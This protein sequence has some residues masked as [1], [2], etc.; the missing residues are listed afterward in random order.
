MKAPQSAVVSKRRKILRPPTKNTSS[1]RG[2]NKYLK[3][4]IIRIITT[5]P[6]K[7]SV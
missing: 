6:V 7:T 3:H 1:A 4:D 5:Y 2:S